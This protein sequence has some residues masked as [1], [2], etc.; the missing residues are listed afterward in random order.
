MR[1][2]LIAAGEYYP[3]YPAAGLAGKITVLLMMLVQE[4]SKP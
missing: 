4:T 2:Y 1:P 3:E